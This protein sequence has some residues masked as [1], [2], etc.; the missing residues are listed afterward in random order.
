ML[1][2]N[3]YFYFFGG[4]SNY[5]VDTK[6]LQMF[7]A[8]YTCCHS[9]LIKFNTFLAYTYMSMEFIELFELQNS[10]SMRDAKFYRQP[11]AI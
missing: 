11:W 10:D 9:K 8:D 5:I 7:T 1:Y 4:W 3:F 2:A 6:Q